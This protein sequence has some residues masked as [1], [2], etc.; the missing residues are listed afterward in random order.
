MPVLQKSNERSLCPE[1][2]SLLVSYYWLWTTCSGGSSSSS[3]T[4]VGAV[5][6]V[7]VV[8]RRLFAGGGWVLLNVSR[9]HV[10][11]VHGT[12]VRSYLRDAL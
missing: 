4:G 11:S 10:R 8:Q 6:V 1:E 3:E 12:D 5:R 7:L 9:A 2:L